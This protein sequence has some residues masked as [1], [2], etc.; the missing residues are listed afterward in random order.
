M[1]MPCLTSCLSNDEP[2][3][4][5]NWR[6]ANDEWMLAKSIEKDAAGNLV[7]ERV[8]CPWDVDGYVLMK[9]HNSRSENASK[10]S[11]IS[12]STIDVKY[13]VRTIDDVMVDNSHSRVTPAPGVYRSVLNKNIS[14]WLIGIS[15]MHIGDTCT[16]LIPYTQAYG[17]VPYNGL[18][19]YSN[20]I[21]NVRLVDIP[22]FEKP[23]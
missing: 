5:N 23:I 16:I 2:N 11:P 17:S 7:Y 9:W 4:G 8:T 13:E 19:G 15:Q 18:K 20:L 1:L 10:L 22:A 14:G 3:S 12:T 21:F 6:D